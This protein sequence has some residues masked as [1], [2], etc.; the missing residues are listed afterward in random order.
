MGPVVRAAA[1]GEVAH[2]EL[3]AVVAPARQARNNCWSEKLP[4]P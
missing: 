3:V 4:P 1:A 2:F